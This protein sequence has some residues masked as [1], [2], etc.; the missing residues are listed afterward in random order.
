LTITNDLLGTQE[1]TTIQNEFINIDGR[2]LKKIKNILSL[3]T[4][5]RHL[6]YTFA[7]SLLMKKGKKSK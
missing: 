7:D 1:P 3:S 5:E 2:T 4:E 6:V